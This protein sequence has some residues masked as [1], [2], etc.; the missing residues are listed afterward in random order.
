MSKHNTL[1]KHAA[2]LGIRSFFQ[3]VDLCIEP[4]GSFWFNSNTHDPRLVQTDRR[5]I[6]FDSA[7]TS[8]ER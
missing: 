4:S 1:L 5:Y 7:A 2:R 6:S 8:R 3:T